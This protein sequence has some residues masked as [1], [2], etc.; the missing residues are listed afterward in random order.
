MAAKERTER[1]TIESST[2]VRRKA[3]PPAA[4]SGD[5]TRG[6]PF[7][8]SPLGPDAD[9]GTLS[10]EWSPRWPWSVRLTESMARRGDGNRDL[11][12]WQPGDPHDLP[13][14]SGTVQREHWT[15]LGAR[16]RLHGRGDFGAALAR[17]HSRDAW[18]LQAELRLDL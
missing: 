16:A 13:F 4:G 17:D 5:P 11:T 1:K 2:R 12:P 3:N 15:E 14:P 7:L 9:H 6:D 10:L 18:R 8:G